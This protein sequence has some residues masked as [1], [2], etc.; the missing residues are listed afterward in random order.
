[1]ADSSEAVD[2]S[3]TIPRRILP[4]IVIA[5]FLGTSLWFVGNAV[6]G[7]VA[8]QWPTATGAVGWLTSSVQLGFIAGTLVYAVLAL[9]DRFAAHRVFFV[10]CVLA[11]AANALS[12][13]APQSLWWFLACRFA[14]G[15]FL[16]GIYPV[17]MKLAASWYQRGL[18]HAIGLLV[19]ALVLGTAFPHLLKTTALP[20]RPVIISASVLA[21]LGGIVVAVGVPEGPHVKRQRGF[22]PR[23]AVAVFRHAGFLRAAFGY[24]GHMWELYALWA[25]VPW[26][27]TM[28]WPQLSPEGVSLGSFAVIAV[29][30]IGCVVGG[31]VSLRRGSA[32]VAIVQLAISGLCCV[33]SPWLLPWGGIPA[34]VLLLVWGITV[35]GDS[36]QFSS[37]GARMAP[38]DGVGTALTMMTMIGFAVTIGS[39]QWLSALAEP[40]EPAWLL[41]IL[42]PGPVVGLIAMAPLW[43][44]DP[45]APT[46]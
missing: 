5:Q 18:G 23:R 39:I 17:G 31:L 14:T 7:E 27:L 36:P 24:F 44:H 38:P 3:T 28:A 32:R 29:G 11:A 16:A 4:L 2:A 10:S 13:V 20:W 37:L 12:L 30:A 21:L 46:P 35:V 42:V 41:L 33:A 26:A 45:T 22:D 34:A 9:A 8:S 43:R 6:A 19:G 25:F 40:G 1:M 15:V